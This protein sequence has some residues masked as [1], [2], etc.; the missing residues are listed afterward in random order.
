MTLRHSLLWFGVAGVLGL[1]VDIAVLTALRDVLGVYGARAASFL[2]AA[3]ATWLVNRHRSFAGRSAGV[4]IWQEYLRYLGLML[5]GGL[6]NLATYSFLAWRFS[7]T[8]LWLAIYV[9][10]G[11]LAGMTVNYLGASQWLYRHKSGK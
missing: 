9:G 2:A 1:V 5:G 3:T 6:V 8:P 11:S 4:G 10:A 7:Q